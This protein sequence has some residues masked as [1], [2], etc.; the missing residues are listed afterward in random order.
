MKAG[1]LVFPGSNC[2]WDCLHII[3]DVLKQK[4]EFI[5]H[6]EDKIGRFDL[7]ILPGG[8]SYGDYLRTGAI[9]KFSPVM[10]AL[11][12]YVKKDRGLVLGICNG[13]QILTE[14]GLLPGA[15][16]K[17][18][19]LKFLCKDVHIRVET[20]KS[21]FTNQCKKGQVL[22]VPI[23][24]FE[25]NYTADKA[26]IEKLNKKNQVLFRYCGKN[27]GVTQKDNPNGSIENIAGICNEARNVLGMM[28]H[29]ERV[30]EAILGGEDGLR[31]FKSILASSSR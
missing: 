22:K 5:W 14:S 21:P 25:G 20:N 1:V 9:A 11:F 31:I 12:E 2:D 29:P 10:N 3:R 27:G 8:F 30:S 17:N 19:H 7:I 16:Q 4:A 6:Q 24:H 15:L 23:A 13:F 28:P 26:T 18:K